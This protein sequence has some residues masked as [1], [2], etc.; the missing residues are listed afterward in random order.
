M[1]AAGSSR[2]SESDSDSWLDTGDIAER[3]VD[4][5]D[6]LRSRLHDTLDDELLAG[7]PKTKPKQQQRGRYHESPLSSGRSSPRR[8][9]VVSKE[10]IVVPDS[11][12][13]R[14]SRCDR[15]LTAMMPGGTGVHGL[16]GKPLM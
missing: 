16:T 5:E 10:A 11:V 7:V 2:S 3:L 4:E 8:A 15:L 13:R 14:P 6:P 12:V 9:G 1:G